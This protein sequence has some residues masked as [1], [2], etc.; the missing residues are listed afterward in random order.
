MNNFD[1]KNMTPFKW[2]VLEN[3][4][5]IENDFDA[6]NNYHLFSKVVEYLNK[7]I[8]NMN[9]TGQQMEN[10]TNAMTDLQDYVNDYFENLD[11]QNEINNKLD[12]MVADGTLY[13]IMRPYFNSVDTE[14]A[15]IENKVN[16]VASGSPAGVYATVS[17][18]TTADPDHSRIYVVSADGH[19]YYYGN[20]QWN[21]GGDYQGVLEDDSIINSFIKNGAVSPLKTSFL[22]YSSNNI[23]EDKNIFSTINDLSIIF[24]L[25]TGILAV[26]GTLPDYYTTAHR[27]LFMKKYLKSGNYCLRMFDYDGTKPAMYARSESDYL[28]NITNNPVMTLGAGSFATNFSIENDGYYYFEFVTGNISYNYTGKPVLALGNYSDFTVYIPILFNFKSFI[29]LTQNNYWN[30]K[31]ILFYGDSLTAWATY[32]S[33]IANYFKMQSNNEGIAGS[34]ASYIE[35]G[36]EV[37]TTLSGS[38][39]S[40]LTTLIN[41]NDIIVCMFG[42]NDYLNNVPLGNVPK[43]FNVNDSFDVSTFAGAMLKI[44][45]YL[46]T[47]N[48]NARIILMCPPWNHYQNLSNKT[49]LDYGNIVKEI[50]R[51]TST[52]VI[53]LHNELN[54]NAL[55]YSYYY[56]DSGTHFNNAGYERVAELLINKIE[57]FT[58]F[59]N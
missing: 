23:F 13:N 9:I 40:R 24:N 26:Q 12:E 17:D 41:N 59:E 18:L 27:T 54:T 53:D 44:I 7:T 58:S 35:D 45:H 22:Q 11:V 8:D 4:P 19:W 37:Q 2:F 15:R 39:T 20:S 32:P 38:S 47:N 16:S 3:F 5:F 56:S 46:Y 51:L 55:N 49:L 28:N 25:E 6:I 52:P 48:P 36:S 10:V 34:T 29:S 42:T 1:Y 33:I 57:E 14:I 43:T 30:N 21:D 50:G 31:K